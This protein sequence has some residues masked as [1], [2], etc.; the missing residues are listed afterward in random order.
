MLYLYLFNVVS[1]VFIS[2]CW[3]R[4]DVVDRLVVTGYIL[5]A[6]VNALAAAHELG[7][8]VKV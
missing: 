6:I 5:G 7:Y 4:T 3:N 2:V 8:I 1:M